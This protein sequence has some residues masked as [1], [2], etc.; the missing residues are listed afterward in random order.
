[1]SYYSSPGRSHDSDQA[2]CL[3]PSCPL[4]KFAEMWYQVFLWAL[5]SSLFVHVVAAVIAFGTLRKH[6]FGKFFP[7][8]IIVMGII[9]PATCGAVSSAAI[10]LVY[11]SANLQMTSLHAMFWG[12]G[13]TVTTICVS[14]TRILATL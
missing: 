1:M 6:K 8:F 14:F 7:I 11:R 9:T 2:T 12:T 3:F 4:Q 5:F 10:A 13:Q